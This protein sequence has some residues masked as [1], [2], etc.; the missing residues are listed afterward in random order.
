[1]ASLH[2]LL[3]TFL[4]NGAINILMV[5]FDSLN[6]FRVLAEYFPNVGQIVLLS[7]LMRGDVELRLCVPDEVDVKLLLRP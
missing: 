5:V 3:F 4:C 7:E 6:E 1:M 2:A